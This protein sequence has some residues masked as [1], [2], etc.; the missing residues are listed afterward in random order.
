MSDAPE[1]KRPYF[2]FVDELKPVQ[3]TDDHPVVQNMHEVLDQV[4]ADAIEKSAEI[5]EEAAD[6]AAEKIRKKNGPLARKL[7]ALVRSWR[8]ADAAAETEPEPC[9]SPK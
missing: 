5:P 3:S 8:K 7:R 9:P 1:R 6:V 2:S 4:E